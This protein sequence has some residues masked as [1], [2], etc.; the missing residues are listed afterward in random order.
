MKFFQSLSLVSLTFSVVTGCTADETAEPQLT[1]VSSGDGEIDA[2][3]PTQTAAPSAGTPEER[4]KSAKD[5][6]FDQ[7]STRLLAS[8]STE[9]PAK[10]IEVCSKLAPKIA[11]EVG[12]QHGVTIG[13]TG[14][15]LR[16]TQNVPPL[17][18]EPLLKDLPKQPVFTKL[19]DGRTGALFPIMLKMQ[20]LT[21]HGP[22]DK[23][24]E[25]IRSE[26]ARLYPNDRATG[27]E[28]GELRGWFWVEVPAT[29]EANPT[30]AEA[31]D[32]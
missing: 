12:Q 32:I 29:E 31:G 20:C 11:T 4:A 23:I 8:M 7:L 14:V 22:A 28:E 16:N 3:D 30:A 17:W 2:K 25:D 5:S 9:G 21:C 24:A 15:R 6:L 27:F 1:S 10:A 26:L 13:R 19:D 18:A